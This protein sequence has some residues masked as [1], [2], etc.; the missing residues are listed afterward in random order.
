MN[1]KDQCVMLIDEEE[2]QAP[3]PRTTDYKIGHPLRKS[4]FT[5]TQA[6]LEKHRSEMLNQPTRIGNHN[7]VN[8]IEPNSN[9]KN[10]DRSEFSNSPELQKYIESLKSQCTP[11]TYLYIPIEVKDNQLACPDYHH[12]VYYEVNQ[13]ND[14]VVSDYTNS[15]DTGDA[16]SE[17]NK[18]VAP[19]KE[20]PV[21]IGRYTIKERREKIRKYKEKILRWKKGL[22]S[23]KERYARRRVLAQAKPRFQGRFI[24]QTTT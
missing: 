15:L 23:T 10:L 2:Y 19:Q 9:G 7:S 22:T 21:T 4:G 5:C 11:G 24:K 17:D 18:L 1:C 6:N 20:E 14:D 12:P 8:Q 13:K 3:I 16:S